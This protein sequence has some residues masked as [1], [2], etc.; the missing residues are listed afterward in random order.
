ML[1]IT[2]CVLL[3]K[4]D[5]ELCKC[6]LM[7]VV[8]SLFYFGLLIGVGLSIGLS[9]TIPVLP[10][11]E[12]LIENDVVLATTINNYVSKTYFTSNANNLLDVTFYHDKCL[13]I[14]I[15]NVYQNYSQ[16][17]NI[18]SN[19]QY[20]IDQVYMIK[21]SEMSYTFS[22]NLSSMSSNSCVASIPRLSH[23]Q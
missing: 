5:T 8:V 21:G 4:S 14:P 20:I 3:C 11:G 12:V 10:S 19:M 2:W 22:S 1:C 16:R 9:L 13:E 15:K 17:L 18:T 6:T 7:C 23:L